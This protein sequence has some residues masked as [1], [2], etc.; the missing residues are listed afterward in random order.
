VRRL[1]LILSIA[2][3]AWAALVLA[4]G[5]VDWRIAGVFF[6]SRTPDR[7]LLIALALIVVQAVLFK[8]AFSRDVL[9]LSS[10]VRAFLPAVAL[11]LAGTLAVHAVHF[12]TFV[13][14]GADAFGYVS[15]AYSWAAGRL[16]H[17]QPI[18]LTVSWPSGDASLAPLGYRPG[19]QP[20]T[21][22]PTYAPGL[23]LMMAAFLPLGSCG[24]YL[25]VPACAA[26]VVWL[27]FILGRRAGGPWTGVLAALFVTTSPIVRFQSVWPMSDI[28]AAALWTGAAC[29]ALGERRRD[30]LMCGMWTAAGLLMRPNLPIVPVVLFLHLLVTARARERWV[31]PA[32]FSLPVALVVCFIAA[33]YT[34][35]YGAP[36]KSGYGAAGEIFLASNILP[37]LSRYPVWLWQSQS[38]LIL[39]ALVPLWSRMEHANRTAV[40][41][42]AALFVATLAS[43]LVYSPFEEWWYL[44]FLLPA[45]PALLVLVA[46]GIVM[47]ARRL[48]PV[49]RS[50]TV[51]ASV[52]VLVALTTW[53]TNL[54]AAPGPMRDAERRYADVGLFIGQSL[55]ANAVVFAVQESGSVRHYGGRMTIRWDLIDRDWASRAVEEV[56]RQGLHPYLLVEDFELPQVRDWF[57]IEANAPLPWGLVARM[58]QN[59]GVSVFDMAAPAG[60]GTPVS[61]E[62]GVAA[63][64]QGPLP[65]VL[66]PR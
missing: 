18:P 17:A 41:L 14:G 28:P 51:I 34:V 57:G 20:H 62:S 40:W 10:A 16:P 59:G 13:A 58:R 9:R 15:Q 56:R 4:T 2:A 47:S 26:L 43:Y 66:E 60:A 61:L 36:W 22:V 44:R 12:G 52:I 63:R 32:L 37:N 35:W 27:T 3:L 5:G 11:L 8:D 33:L 24:P 29:A 64:C 25:V 30:A 42:C 53:Y 45:I 19:L 38:P 55:P 48:P 49:W 6:R 46:A 54:R 31:R 7:A 65:L 23:P 1:L 21:M 39:L 50:L